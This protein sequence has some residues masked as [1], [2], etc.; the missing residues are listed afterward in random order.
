MRL[1]DVRAL[2]RDDSVLNS[3]APDT[4]R[5]YNQEQMLQVKS[6]GYNHEVRGVVVA[7]EE[8]AVF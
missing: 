1:P 7:R 2:L 8:I 5:E 4:F 3:S 6:P